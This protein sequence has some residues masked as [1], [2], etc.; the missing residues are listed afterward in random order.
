MEDVLANS[1]TN[2]LPFP[3]VNDHSVKPLIVQDV[4]CFHLLVLARNLY[5]HFFFAI[6]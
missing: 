6:T 5:F 2:Q 1:D 4:N 3:T